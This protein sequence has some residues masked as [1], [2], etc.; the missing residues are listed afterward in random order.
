MSPAS[1]GK[2]L[3]Q[4]ASTKLDNLT[5]SRKEGLQAM[6][7]SSPRQR[8][9]L[10]TVK[11]LARL[12][13]GARAEYQ[14]MRSVWHAN[15]GPLKTPQL[16]SLQEDL[17]DIVDSNRQDGDKTKG[18]VAVDAFPGLGKTTA[19]LNFALKYHRRE[20]ERDGSFTDSGHERWPVC[21]VGLTS[22]IGM[23][24][25]NRALLEF[26]AH[27][28]RTSGTSAL[29]VQRA[30]DC[31]LQCETKL[32]IIDDLHFL[33][34]QAKNGKEVSNHFKY[35]ANEFPVTL[36]FIGVE[37][38][39]RGLYSEIDETGDISLA[40]TA[41]RTT[42]LTLDPFDVDNEQH[43]EQWR[44]LLLALEQR[45]VLSRAAPGMLADKLSDYLFFRTTGHIG[46][47]MTLINRGCQRAVRSGIEIL[48]EE[49]LEQV[50]IDAA[51]ERARKALEQ[52]FREHRLTS[53][54]GSTSRSKKNRSTAGAV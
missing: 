29:F 33:K 2:S 42:P 27:P 47:L 1:K 46:S 17:W 41:R 49:L 8:P 48:S 25:F 53:K 35:I 7:N 30:L 13:T 3:S 54:P 9:D 6:A 38:E 31:V 50:K 19:V 5:M 26:Y 21:R 45:I 32:L 43:R 22:N 14:D 24:D 34:W 39:Q 51:S 18:A 20:I 10:L 37:L 28:G 36:I 11:Q 15:I 4:P 40:Q 44:N 23:K 12:S 52:K 16:Q